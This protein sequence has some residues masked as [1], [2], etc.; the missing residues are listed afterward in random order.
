MTTK[1]APRGAMGQMG[2]VLDHI[3]YAFAEAEE[4]EII[5]QGKTDV[6]DSFWRYVVA[7]GHEWNFAYV[8]PKKSGK[9]TG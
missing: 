5:F 8:L 4:D 3:I 9:S 7:K 1:T 6:K 2:R